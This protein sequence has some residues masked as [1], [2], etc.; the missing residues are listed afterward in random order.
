MRDEN[1]A[2]TDIMRAFWVAFMFFAA[3]LMGCA[4][5]QHRSTEIVSEPIVK[6]L[7]VSFETDQFGERPAIIAVA[8]V[9]RL[10]EE[11]QASFLAYFNDPA[12]QGI[13]AHRRVY[14]YLES[15]TMNFGYQGETFAAEEALR[16]SSGNCLSLAI[17]T[18]ALAELAGV[19]TG[20]QLVDSLPV[21]ESQGNVVFRGQHVRTK[22]FEPARESADG[23]PVLR[24]AGLLVDYFAN[25][26][27]RF[28][29]NINEAEYQAMYYNNLA[30]EAISRED[31]DTAFWLLKE[32]LELTPDNAGAINSMAIVYRRSGDMNKAEEIYQYGIEN[33]PNKV[34]LLR[35]YRVLLQGQGRFSEAEE[36]NTKLA[37]LDEG[38]PFDWLHVGHEAYTNGDF[39]EAISFYQKAVEIAPYLH[40]SYA[41]MA[42]AHYQLG[43]RVRARRELLNAQKFSYR[44]SFQS[45]YQSKLM[46]LAGEH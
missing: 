20:Y 34:S 35:N 44:K 26:G 21:F 8:D 37:K 16:E 36:I 10:S 13:P 4:P 23:N 25:D 14:E 42:K 24:R 9:Y 45:L 17:L 39:R 40:E 28:V 32:A 41:G 6:N 29:S 31:Y 12:R 30:S 2:T 22:L 46:A 19:E 3:G 18:T 27:D 7:A 11:Q 5:V 38:S 15:T 43:N 33:L 1:K